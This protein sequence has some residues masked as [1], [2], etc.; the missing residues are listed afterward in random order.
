MIKNYIWD[1]DGTLYDTYPIMLEAIMRTLDEM[2]VTADAAAIY[3][4]LKE[5]SSKKI[6]D[7]LGL[8]YQPFS[9]QFHDY[10]EADL[11]E[12]VSFPGTKET[13]AALQ[14]KGARHFIMTH[15]P[16]SSTIKLLDQEGLTAYFEEI[17]GPENAFPRKPDPAAIQYILQAHALVPT[18]TVMIG[19]RLL[20]VE[21]GARAG[22][23]T[24]F[25]DVDGFLTDIPADFTVH[26]MAEV[27]EKVE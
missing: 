12:P 10:E 1:F 20:D 11:R 7:D 23:K 2:G 18:E 26:G 24:C 21:A 6:T 8:A 5:F 16:V 4:T 9:D 27:L 14:A 25:F 17:V 13:L 15:R 3:R 19:D 22:V